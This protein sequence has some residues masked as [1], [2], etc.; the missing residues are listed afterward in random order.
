MSAVNFPAFTGHVGERRR[1]PNR[2]S[3][4]T[5]AWRVMALRKFLEVS[6]VLVEDLGGGLGLI[7][8][9]LYSRTQATLPRRLRSPLICEMMAWSPLGSCC[10]YKTR[11]SVLRKEKTHF[12]F[13][14]W[15]DLTPSPCFGAS[16]SVGLRLPL[17]ALLRVRHEAPPPSSLPT[18]AQRGL[19]GGYFSSAA[20]WG[21]S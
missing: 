6:R 1:C 13:Y 21:K 3:S 4:Q 2:Y 10:C 14:T 15:T 19:R 16:D 9:S 20:T 11:I 12:R 7:E 17:R 5:G 18:C 8:R